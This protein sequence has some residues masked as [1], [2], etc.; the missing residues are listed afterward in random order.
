MPM[1][2]VSSLWAN[3]VLSIV[4]VFTLVVMIERIAKR[5]R[6]RSRTH[7]IEQ[8]LHDGT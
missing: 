7:P 8:D 5:L 6:R 2:N 1:F 4:L 3:L